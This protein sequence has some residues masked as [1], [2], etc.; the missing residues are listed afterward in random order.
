MMDEVRT[1]VASMQQQETSLE[2]QRLTAYQQSVRTTKVCVF[3]ASFVAILGLFLLAYTIMR[4]MDLRERHERMTA[5][6]EEW[7]RATLTSLGDGVIA[8]D[9]FGRVTFLNLVAE[10]LIGFDQQQAAGKPITEVFPIFNEYTLQPVENP[11]KKVLQLGHVIGLANHTVLQHKDGSTTPIE[12]SAAPIRDDRDRVVGVV[13]V[14]R[15]ASQERKAQE[16]MR[17]SEKLAAAARLAA[18]VAHEINNPLESVGNLLYLAKTTPDLPSAAFDH[19]TLAEQELDRVAHITR[20]TL[21]FYRESRVGD[22]VPVAALVE[23]V[24]N[25][26]SNKL[27]SKNITVERDFAECPPVNGRTGE[28]K[29]VIANIISNAID[30]V[31]KNGTVRVKVLCVA[32]KGVESAQIIIEDDGPGIPP[33]LRD[34]IFEPFFTTKTDVGTGLGLWVVK[35]IVDRHRRHHPTSSPATTTRPARHSESSSHSL[36]PTAMAITPRRRPRSHPTAA[37]SGEPSAAHSGEPSVAHAGEPSAAHAGNQA[38]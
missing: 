13:L 16:I 30:A 8:T 27:K 9:R 25:L 2:D 15:D 17:K 29:Q 26:Y 4:E 10:Q 7:F 20:Q 28:L 24:L 31:S 12:D 6:R 14:F 21:G 3:L 1:L 37:H 19:L 34:R 38:L 36:Q 18:T 35:E 33:E 23:S 11:V 5:Q 22:Q 32:D